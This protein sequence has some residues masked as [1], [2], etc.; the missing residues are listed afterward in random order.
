MSDAVS[1]LN[2]RSV[3]AGRMSLREEGLCGMISLRGDLSK[4]ALRSVCTSLTG[5]D[6]PKAGEAKVEGRKGLCWMSPDEV[7]ILLEHDHTAEARAQIAAALDGVH[8]LATDVS[9][10][11]AMF[12]LEGPFVREVLAKLAPVDLHPDA[13]PPGRFR[14]SRLGQVAAAFWLTEDTKARIICF[15]SVADY[16]FNLLQ[17]SC[18]SG[19]VGHFPRGT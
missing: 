4:T 5:R 16:A 6:F 1:A 3:T 15:R 8:H 13:F 2:E 7:L 18:K 19:P 11:R 9:D 14:R 12:T 17:A 10:A